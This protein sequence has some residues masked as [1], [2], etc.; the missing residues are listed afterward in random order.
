MLLGGLVAGPAAGPATGV[1]DDPAEGGLWYY[2][3]PGFEEIHASG[4]TG[5][6][7]TVAVIDGPIYPDSP[8]L[9]GTNLVLPETSFC[10]ED[11]DG[12]DLPDPVTS[13]MPWAEHATTLSGLIIG[14]GTGVSG[15]P[16]VRGVAP[17]ATV[18]LYV[19][20]T[21]G[22]AC[23]LDGQDGVI[24]SIDQ[25][26]ADGADVINLSFS[27]TT[28]G[29]DRI[30][31]LAR[32]QRAGVII[33]AASYHEGGTDL[34][35]PALA[36]GVIAVESA[37]VNLTLSPTSVT[38]PQLTVVAPG[39][40]IRALTHSTNW[41]GY[42]LASGTS[43]ATAWTS[44]AL[45]LAWSAHPDATANQM[46]QALLRTTSQSDGNLTRIDDHWGY[47]TVNARNLVEIDPTTLPDVHPLLSQ[48]PE[49]KPRYEDVL[50]PEPEPTAEPTTEPTPEPTQ[51]TP[52]PDPDTDPAGP[53]P[54]ILIGALA[55]V[56]LVGATT[57][58]VLV[59]RRRTTPP[60]TPPSPPTLGG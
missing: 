9:A 37:D 58:V 24:L 20:T 29:T 18:R 14:T 11:D 49:A 28:W 45:A 57:A 42:E 51:A 30:A 31:A 15:E 40:H 25:A 48:D 47:G 41:Q 7:I 43:Y 50:D 38:H 8:D 54:A 5:E 10:D 56:V 53:L 34:G 6:G 46:I 3:V 17:G 52:A 35:W 36:N 26:I 32:A 44:G 2:T 55:L 39:A 21:L 19:S 23:E 27:G 16:G 22:G 4:V 33:V 1:T 13:R 59:R 12:D 60:P